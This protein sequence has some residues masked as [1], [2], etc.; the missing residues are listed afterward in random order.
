MR[1]GVVHPGVTL[2]E[3]RAA[4]GFALAD[5]AEAPPPTPPPDAGYL[6]VLRHEV[7]PT[8]QRLREFA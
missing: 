3:V 4:T 2:D 8:S 1:I 6:E 5:T 7:D